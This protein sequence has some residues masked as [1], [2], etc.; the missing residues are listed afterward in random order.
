MLAQHVWAGTVCWSLCKVTRQSW[1][2]LCPWGPTNK[3]LSWNFQTSSEDP[4]C[5]SKTTIQPD[6]LISPF[7]IST[8]QKAVQYWQ[9]QDL[10][11]WVSHSLSC[12]FS[13]TPKHSFHHATENNNNL[14]AMGML[15][16]PDGPTKVDHAG[17]T[18]AAAAEP[19]PTSESHLV[20]PSCCQQCCCEICW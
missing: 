1:P 8:G 20:T 5:V 19:R 15:L 14:L 12:G 6:N 13:D 3:G 7:R 17:C 2:A 11:T 4:I 10:L 9:P 18:I 16:L